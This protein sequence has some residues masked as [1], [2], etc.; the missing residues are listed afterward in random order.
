ML[1]ATLNGHDTAVLVSRFLLNLQEASQQAMKLPSDHP[2][3]FSTN[4]SFV[5]AVGATIVPEVFS[6][7]G[8]SV[9]EERGH[10]RRSIS[11]DEA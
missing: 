6:A 2:L 4:S 3:H 10:T 11:Y 8:L 5:G 7:E 9:E 1:T